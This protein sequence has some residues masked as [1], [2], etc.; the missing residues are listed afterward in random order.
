MSFNFKRQVGILRFEKNCY[1]FEM[2]D[3]ATFA[4]LKN[5]FYVPLDA[6][7]MGNSKQVLEEHINGCLYNKAFML[8]VADP[9]NKPLEMVCR[10]F[11]TE[12]SNVIEMQFCEIDAL[13]DIFSERKMTARENQALIAQ[14]SDIIYYYNAK[15]DSFTVARNP[16]SDGIYSASLEKFEADAKTK[17]TENSYEEFEKFIRA[18][19]AGTRCFTNTV[20]RAADGVNLDFTGT[21]IYVKGEYIAAIGRMG[22][23]SMPL[24]Q[25]SMY[26]QL[27][28]VLLK[29]NIADY[30]KKRIDERHQRTAIAI[31]DV[32]NFKMI[33]DNYGHQEGDRV[34]CKIASILK[35]SCAGLGHVGRIGGDEFFVVYDNF[36]DIFDI[37]FTLM[38]MQSSMAMEFAE[39]RRNGINITLSTGCSVFPDDYN[40]S[41][42]DMFKLADTFLYR[43]KDK[44][45]DRY[46]VYNAAKHGP[47]EE[48]LKNGFEKVNLDKSK[49]VCN[50]ADD[51]ICGKV[52]EPESVLLDIKK[53]FTVDRVVLYNKTDRFLKAQEGEGHFSFDVIRKTIRYLYDE[54]LTR[55][56]KDGYMMINNVEH[57]RQRAPEVFRILKEQG[58]QSIQ[59]YVINADSGKQYILSLEMVSSKCTWNV[60]DVQ[61][62]RIIVK[63]LEKIL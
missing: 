27:T 44:G 53:Y 10:I 5:R 59:Q 25:L 37:R 56:Y 28:G 42:E 62:Y 9:D 29:N 35:R 19:K 50:L 58:M 16:A 26:D 49:Y 61:Y 55:E 46:I 13:C 8:T 41:F 43:A 22:G 1:D 30:A 39:F 31:I 34:L 7:L 17:L 54:G 48:L 14:H 2:S 18:V 33:N 36:D 11:P 23:Q 57:F 12:D 38:G 60:G 6:L 15:T 47:V 4:L 24:A 52:P 45:K 21:A 32:D 51:I 3:T 20:T 63:V 40:G